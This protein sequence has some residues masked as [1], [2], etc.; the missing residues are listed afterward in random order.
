MREQKEIN[1][2]VNTTPDPQRRLS[3][4]S[5]LLLLVLMPSTF[6]TVAIASLTPLL[7][8]TPASVHL[9]IS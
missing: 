8:L 7:Y 3:S 6:T 4:S 5:A 1:D 9:S 2:A